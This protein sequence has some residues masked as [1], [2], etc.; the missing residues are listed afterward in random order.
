MAR[1]WSADGVRNTPPDYVEIVWDHDTGGYEW[2]VIAF[3]R[4]PRG[5][6]WEY[7]AY[8]DSGCSC[9]YAYEDAP[10]SC[11]LDWTPSVAVAVYRTNAMIDKSYDLDGP[12][13]I[14]AKAKLRAAV[15]AM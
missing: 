12:E 13:R 1:Y 7:A 2:S 11:D 9:N 5:A 15:E 8:N 4:R 14:D 10:K 6:E 3:L